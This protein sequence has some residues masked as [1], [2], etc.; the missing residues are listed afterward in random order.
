[1]RHIRV[2]VRY[3]VDQVLDAVGAVGGSA[4]AVPDAVSGFQPGDVGLPGGGLSVQG[5]R[6]AQPDSTSDA[7]EGGLGTAEGR[8][9]LEKIDGVIIYAA[10]FGLILLE[11][12]PWRLVVC[13][14]W[15]QQ[16]GIGMGG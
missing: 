2:V 4:L 11:L 12:P 16:C 15:C 9:I 10:G 1:M 5:G 13:N 14:A 7:C 3:D 6:C 8:E